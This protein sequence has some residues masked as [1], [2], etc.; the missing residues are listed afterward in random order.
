MNLWIS[1]EE[2]QA[3]KQNPSDLT[4]WIDE[5]RHTESTVNKFLQILLSNVGTLNL[6]IGND[7]QINVVYT[8][9]CGSSS[10]FRPILI[11]YEVPTQNW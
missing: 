5:F 3:Y 11:R 2:Q 8:I 10:T 7:L 4:W 1:R 6:A 9:G